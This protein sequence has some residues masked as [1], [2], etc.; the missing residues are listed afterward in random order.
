MGDVRIDL[1]RLSTTADKALQLEN[2][3]DDAEGFADDI[4][5]LTGHDGLAD[6]VEDFGNDWD[7]AREELREGLAAVA[8]F[9][10]AIHD[11][12]LDLDDKMAGGGK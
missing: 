9:M 4:G 7:V 11:T 1:T 12:F 5:S 10:E 3:F 8:E 2:D 6:R